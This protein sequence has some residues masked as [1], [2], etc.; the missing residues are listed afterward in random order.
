MKLENIFVNFIFHGFFLVDMIISMFLVSTTK[1]EFGQWQRSKK[2]I[3]KKYMKS[4]FLIDFLAF[5]PFFL[6]KKELLCTEL[7]R[8][9]KIGGLM[10]CFYRILFKIVSLLSKKASK[11]LTIFNTS[12]H[13]LT[14]CVWMIVLAHLSTMI[15][16]KISE[17]EGF[18]QSNSR[19]T[20]LKDYDLEEDR[21]EIYLNAL[22]LVLTSLVTTGDLELAITTNLQMISCILNGFIGTLMVSY[23]VTTTAFVHQKS[24]SVIPLTNRVIFLYFLLK[25]FLRSQLEN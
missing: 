17:L 6:I 23:A 18:F 11:S 7:L 14:F 22:Y 20:W 3:F 15:F 24:V 2:V 16:I 19:V 9:H 21:G 4:W 13:I 10:E 25:I 5:F 1:N 8:L 12:K